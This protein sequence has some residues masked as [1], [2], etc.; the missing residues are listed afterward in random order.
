[1]KTTEY[2]ARIEEELAS[3]KRNAERMMMALDAVKD[4]LW[5]YDMEND[6]VY[7]SPRYYTMLGYEPYEL[8]QSRQTWIDLLHPEDREKTVNHVDYCIA[9][10]LSWSVEFRLRAK[11]GDYR[12]ILG[13]GKVAVHGKNG[14]VFR[15]VGTHTD[16]TDSKVVETQLKDSEERY[17][18]IFTLIP[19]PIWELD[20]SE[21]KKTLDMIR[22]Q[23]NADLGTYLAENPDV[24]RGL[25]AKI[26]VLDINPAVLIL[27]EAEEKAQVIKKIDRLFSEETYH[28][29]I[30]TIVNLVEQGHSPCQPL[31]ILTLK[32]KLLNL[33]SNIIIAP[34]FEHDW[35]RALVAQTDITELVEAQHRAESSNWSKSIFLAN[36]SHD[37]RT[38]I[39]GVMGMLQLLQLEEL[40]E[41]QTGYVDMGISSCKRLSALLNDILDLSQVEA[42]KL[43]L[44]VRPFFLE[45]IFRALDEMFFL[46]AEKKGIRLCYSQG[47][48]V[49]GVFIGDDRRLL[50]I[51]MN[52]VGNAIKFS[53][54][55]VVRISVEM[56]HRSE[57]KGIALIHI[58]D[59]GIGM[60]PDTLS[61]LFEAFTQ[62]DTG[63]VRDGSGLGLA[64]VKKLVDL[65]GGEICVVSKEGS[66]TEFY[67]NLLMAFEEQETVSDEQ[68]QT[69]RK[70]VIFPPF[71]AL[72]IED[73]TI[74]SMVITTMLENFGGTVECA[75]TGLNGVEKLKRTPYDLVILDVQLPDMTGLELVGTIRTSAGLTHHKT[76]PVIAMTANAMAGDREKCLAAGMTDYMSK[77]V[78]SNVLLSTLDKY[79]GQQN[80]VK[81]KGGAP[82]ISQ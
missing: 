46:T 60:D 52:L 23:G 70:D 71:T 6:E 3:E 62:E 40:A 51:L 35:S 2:I 21:L 41:K 59:D 9:N 1:M 56:N 22:K 45:K 78:E 30:G 69:I 49:P 4:G 81:V 63:V 11:N 77:P 38:P 57:E 14:E 73:D 44:S 76:T 28:V 50:Q 36:M 82:F 54:G 61:H 58:S 68:K 20:L 65:M 39:N 37:L 25:L 75:F 79:I 7:F 24:V 34:G 16:V 31:R 64:I 18:N 32:G 10:R 15:R 42:G 33:R 8:P 48:R 55:G 17:R 12:W 43:S 72:V 29:T 5:D 53:N 27:L 47:E 19:S 26:I 66:G 13:R 67:I 74:S 80:I